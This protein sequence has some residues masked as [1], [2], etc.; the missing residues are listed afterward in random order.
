MYNYLRLRI[1]KPYLLWKKGKCLF[2]TTQAVTVADLLQ[3]NYTKFRHNLN[4]LHT[5]I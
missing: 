4:A 1:K 3:L 5:A 2:R